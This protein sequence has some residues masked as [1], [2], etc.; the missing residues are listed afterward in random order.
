MSA[1]GPEP[2]HIYFNLGACCNSSSMKQ[3][4]SSKPL[5]TIISTTKYSPPLSRSGAEE[6]GRGAGEGG[7]GGRGAGVLERAR[8]C[9][10]AEERPRNE[11]Q[12][13]N[14]ERY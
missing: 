6:G 1:N 2:N 3:Y 13:I 5:V 9:C 7:G 12:W 10:L 4:L 11:R 8:D 14:D